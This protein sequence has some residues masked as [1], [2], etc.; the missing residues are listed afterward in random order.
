LSRSTDPLERVTNLIA[1]LLETRT[2][3]TLDQIADALEGQ[4]PSGDVA[5]RAAFERDKAMLR[6]EGIP[7]ETSVLGGD[8]AGQTAYR[9]DRRRYELD[10]DL[11]PEETRALQLAVATVRLGVAWGDEALLK[12]GADRG[13]SPGGPMLA[14]PSLPALP[15]L[16]DAATAH[17]TVQFTYGGLDRRVDPYGL[18]AR[19]GLWYVIGLDHGRGERRTFRVDR[20][21][22]PV[23]VGEAGAFELPADVDLASAVADPKTFGG[24]PVEALVAIAPVRAAKVVQEVGAGA[25]AE[26]RAD[27]TVVVRVP[28]SNLDAFRSWV[29]GL[30]DDAEVLSPHEARAGIASWLE[31]MAGVDR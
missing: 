14:L 7:I 10:L 11:T 29:L 24:A 22:S 8:H 6:A 3:L 28:C 13:E 16:F 5:R 25:V 26:R 30:L 27:G 4:Y 20:I 9:I 12:L 21:E 31:A 18:L 17:A 15:L 1:L 19:S 23:T 2:P